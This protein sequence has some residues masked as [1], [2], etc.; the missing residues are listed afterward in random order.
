MAQTNRPAS[1]RA[2]PRGDMMSSNVRST[3]AS[4][5]TMKLLCGTALVSSA[6]LFSTVANAQN[7]TVTVTGTSIRGTA[8]VGSNIISVDRT[9]IEESGTT[10]ISELM[11]N[12]PQVS[13]AGSA[14][15]FGSSGQR[16]ETG[17]G[18]VVSPGIHS[19]G[20]Q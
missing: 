18:N 13:G 9:T 10:T 11:S 4:A 16:Q 14:N 6:M 8:P 5:Y 2:F 1:Q 7:E 15:V 3:A 19:L 12:I 17:G 20:T